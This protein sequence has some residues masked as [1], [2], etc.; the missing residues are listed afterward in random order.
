MAKKS[1]AE[2]LKMVDSISKKINEKAGKEIVGRLSKNEAMNE[3]LKA[4]FIPTP[5]M[6]V[7][8]AIGGGWPVGN[9]S[10]VCGMEDSGKT[11]I[12]LETIAINQKNNPDFLAVW[13]ES[14]N[15]L[16]ET[17]L[18]MFGIDRDRFILIEHDRAGA[19]EE[20][21]NRLEAMLNIQ[22]DMVV[23]NSL[24]CLVPSEEFKKDMNSLQVGV[25]SRMNSKM[26]RKLTAVVEENEIA[27]VIV[28]HMSTQIGGMVMG[29]PMTLSGGVA[30]RY[31]AMLIVDLRKR[32]IQETDPIKREDGMKI[33]VTVKKNHVVTNRN[34]YVKTEYF[35]IYGQGTEIYIEAID[36]AIKQGILAKA[37]AFIR[38]PD[39]NGD[40]KIING[41]KMQ[42]QGTAKFRAYCMEN[43]EF[44]ENLKASIKGEVDFLSEEEVSEIKAEEK[45]DN[46]DI[47]EIEDVIATANKAKKGT[48][49]A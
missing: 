13:L 19:G 4:R 41:E 20:A 17:T 45:R 7:N 42:W 11:G 10:I 14:E 27:M 8:E 9:I 48:K 24:K 46:E 35:V 49:T 2:R 38:V 31:G 28:Q 6:N 39:E 26:M 3:K 5:S 25:Q 15:S 12:L 29:D 23:I 18:D 37:G 16:K 21:I 33:G 36:L 30:I 40:A 1:L 43:P 44:F 32:S 34:P 47:G 22:P